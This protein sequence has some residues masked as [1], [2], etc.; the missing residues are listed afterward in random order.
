[1]FRVVFF[2][3]I[4]AESLGGEV[5]VAS[6]YYLLKTIIVEFTSIA[7]A[8]LSLVLIFLEPTCLYKN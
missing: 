2:I 5:E 7:L 3:K 8:Q 4:Q 1:M 6:I